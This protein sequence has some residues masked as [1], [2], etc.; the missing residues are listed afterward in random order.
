MKQKVNKSKE[1]KTVLELSSVDLQS[2]LIPL[3]GEMVMLDSVVANVYGVET[4]R[5]NEAVKNNPEKFPNGYVI[6][7]DFQEITNL[8]SKIS[9]S[10]YSYRTKFLYWQTKTHRKTKKNRW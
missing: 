9:T 2:Q 5:I 4:K 8:R 7:P 1:Q 6:E 3:R 10:S